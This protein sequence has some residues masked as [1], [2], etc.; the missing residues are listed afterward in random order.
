[1]EYERAVFRI[2]DK[3]MEVLRFRAARSV[4]WYSQKALLV[5]SAGLFATLV[6]MHTAFVNKPGKSETIE[7]FGK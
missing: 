6:V 2:Y 4:C 3:S 7:C 1:M 5:L